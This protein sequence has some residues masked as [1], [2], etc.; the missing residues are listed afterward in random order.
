MRPVILK[1]MKKKAAIKTITLKQLS[2]IVKIFNVSYEI[3]L[4]LNNRSGTISVRNVISWAPCI[5]NRINLYV[6]LLPKIEKDRAM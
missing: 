6:F 5:N 4:M 1:F 2:V 3:R